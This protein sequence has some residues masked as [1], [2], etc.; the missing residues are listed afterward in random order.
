MNFFNFVW[1]GALFL[2]EFKVFSTSTGVIGAIVGEISE[3]SLVMS[4]LG[5]GF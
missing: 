2:K 4:I 3:F 1:A 5:S